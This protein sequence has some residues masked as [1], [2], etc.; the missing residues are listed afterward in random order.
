MGEKK[1]NILIEGSSGTGKTLLC[2]QVVKTKISQFEKDRKPGDKPVR[3]IVTKYL[4]QDEKD[5]LLDNFRDNYFANVDVTILPI[6]KLTEEL[7]VTHNIKHPKAEMTQIINS[8][9]SRDQLTILLVDEL[10]ACHDEGQVSADWCDLPNAPNVVWILS[11]SPMGGSDEMVHGHRN[12]YQIR[13]VIRYF[14]ILYFL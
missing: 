11:V 4:R 1:T 9:S 8:I 5:Q 7:G 14:I 12:C 3:V 2:S 13:S 6:D 10:R